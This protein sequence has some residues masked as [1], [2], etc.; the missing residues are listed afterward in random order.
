[1]G[2]T[3]LC[4][5]RRVSQC[6]RKWP[7]SR[8]CAWKQHPAAR[9]MTAC[10]C[11]TGII[12]L[13][14][15]PLGLDLGA[16]KWIP[17]H[18]K[19]P[20]TYGNLRKPTVSLNRRSVVS[21]PHHASTDAPRSTPLPSL[22]TACVKTCILTV[23]SPTRALPISVPVALTPML[24]DTTQRRNPPVVQYHLSQLGSGICPSRLDTCISLT[25]LSLLAAFSLR[26]ASYDP[27][28]K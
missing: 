14:H 6:D 24:V 22:E 5:V 15:D 1:M 21:R 28:H 23:V 17:V 26:F 16:G 20:L 3:P 19:K 27:G 13:D 7:D 12:Q 9:S 18:R 8:A 4:A 2:D 10:P 25:A 11:P